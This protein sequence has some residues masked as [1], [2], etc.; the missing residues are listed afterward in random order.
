MPD[1]REIRQR[2]AEFVGGRTP[3]RDFESWFVSATWDIH[4][5]GDAEATE[6]A[7]EIDLNLAEFS[8]RVIDERELKANLHRL[9]SPPSTQGF[10]RSSSPTVRIQPDLPLKHEQQR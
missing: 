9:A 6:L 7:D 4:R 5:T 2:L 1:A 8:D 3:R 10:F